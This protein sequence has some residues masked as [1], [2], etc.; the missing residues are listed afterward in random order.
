MSRLQ[1]IWCCSARLAY[2]ASIVVLVLGGV[3]AMA[4][5]TSGWERLSIQQRQ[6]L[7]PLQPHWERLDNIRRQKWLKLAARFPTMSDDERAR[8]QERMVGWAYLAPSDRGRARLEF[9]SI[10]QLGSDELQARWQ[11]YQALPAAEREQLARQAAAHA[12]RAAQRGRSSVHTQARP[13]A[14][15]PAATARV[16]TPG[17]TSSF[18]SPGRPR[19]ATTPEFVEPA[20]L[21]PRR[22]AQAA[23]RSSAPAKDSTGSKPRPGDPHGDR[24]DDKMSGGDHPSSIAPAPNR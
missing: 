17:L 14:T 2:T 7:A 1:S 24:R 9:H 4:A 18:Q 12:A 19:I 11:A 20:T 6:A 16:T 15:L 22:G 8:M 10:R 13:P 5:D 23:A 21:L 3:S